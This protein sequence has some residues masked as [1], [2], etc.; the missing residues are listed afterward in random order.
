[1]EQKN[2][3]TGSSQTKRMMVG[4]LLFTLAGTLV[5]AA[6][7]IPFVFESQTLWYKIGVDKYLLRGAQL[8]GVL[9]ALSLF[10]QIVLGV[11]GKFL[12][13][14]FG[15]ATLMRWHRANGVF[16]VVMAL[17]HVSLVLVPEG[18]DNLPIGP[19]YWPEMVGGVLFS[20]ILAMVISSH[21]PERLGLQYGLW[22]RI[23][24][25]LAYI[26][27][28]LAAVHI[29]NVSDSF[30]HQIA[31]VALLVLLV[32]LAIFLLQ[33]KKDVWLKGKVR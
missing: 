21:F 33:A 7:S 24:L 2:K 12:E 17:L 10:F 26:S 16:L 9:V 15:V 23:H 32:V 27:P 1:M 5:G 3:T 8:A 19:K 14:Y 6:L 25:P 29:L 28:M 18:I 20:L 30:E 22:R 11:R 13:G 4:V 31:R